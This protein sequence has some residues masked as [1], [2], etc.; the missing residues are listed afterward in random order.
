MIHDQERVLPAIAGLKRIPVT[1]IV[2]KG[3][4]LDDYLDESVTPSRARV[5]A[6]SEEFGPARRKLVSMASLVRAPHGGSLRTF[7]G[8]LSH[9]NGWL[10]PY[11]A[12][13]L[14]HWQGVAQRA[15]V[16]RTE[17]DFRYD[18]ISTESIYL[19]VSDGHELFEY[20]ADVC[21]TAPSADELVVEVKRDENDLKDERKRKKY[22]LV[23]EVLRRSGYRFEILFKDEIFINRHHRARCELFA[24]RAFV[25]IDRDHLKR[26]EAH[27][28]KNDCMSTYGALA[29]ALE[30]RSRVLGMG[31][32]QAL[33]VQRRV[34]IDLTRRLSLDTPI[35]IH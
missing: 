33:T 16:I 5:R 34:Q 21:L 25:H 22:A 31:V 32:L 2:L 9:E 10:R 7:S 8:G 11:K 27:A 15:L 35:I 1:Q 14:V 12:K 24:S 26:L 3:P 29:E 17:T 4:Q 13:G 28:F 23:A 6:L 19:E 18:K 30:P 20:T